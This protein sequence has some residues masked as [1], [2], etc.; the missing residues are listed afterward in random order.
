MLPRLDRVRDAR[1]ILARYLPETPLVSSPV[2]SDL[3]GA[4]VYLKLETCSPVGS[5]KGRGAIVALAE[6]VGGERSRARRGRAR[7]AGTAIPP[8][9]IRRVVAASTGNHG[10][11]V[12]YAGALFGVGVTIY[13]P[14]RANE[15]KLGQIRLHGA[16]V[17]EHGRDLDEAKAL[18]RESL[19]ATDWFLE[20]GEEPAV[21]VGTATIGLEV[22]DTLPG[23][24]AVIVPVGNGALINGI[25]AVFRQCSP[26]TQ[27]IGVQSTRATC[28][29]HSWRAGRPIP[30]ARCD[31]IADGLAARVPIPSAVALM[32]KTVDDMVLVPDARILRAMC[33]MARE[34]HVLAEPAAAAPLAALLQQRRRF[35]NRSVV[36]IVTGANL[37]PALFGRL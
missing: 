21:T 24:D 12:A 9:T 2:L 7:G 36:L 35:R 34:A 10:T 32:Q 18:A 13:V 4:D 20:D 37:D 26:R 15:T 25:G 27:I 17:I 22:L 31:T 29:A 33:V 8:G 5:F 1:R 14:R 28:M 6:R 11:A 3:T 23:P 16:R 19:G 30:T